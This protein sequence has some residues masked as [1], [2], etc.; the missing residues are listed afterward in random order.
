MRQVGKIGKIN[1]KA[2]KK[3]AKMWLDKDI[4]Y[5]EACKWIYEITKKLDW[6]CMQASDNAHRHGRVWYRGK[7]EELLWGFEQVIRACRKAHTYLDN[8]TK[9]REAVFLLLRG[10]ETHRTR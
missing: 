4:R 7:P 8:N 2:N 9:I 5:C 3:I 10:R 6:A 1:A